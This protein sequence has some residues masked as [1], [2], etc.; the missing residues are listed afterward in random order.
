MRKIDTIIIH[1]SASDRKEADDI[2][3]IRK[4]H[5]DKGWDDVGYHYFIKSDGEVQVGREHKKIGA[6]ALKYNA[7]S[8]GICLHGLH[9]EDFTD[10][11]F[12]A[13]ASLCDDLI[14][15]YNIKSII[16]H[17]FVANKKC[18]VFNVPKEIYR[19]LGKC[20]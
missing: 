13:C 19:R 12:E 20:N 16:P 1:C 10:E 6:H 5:T 14:D 15:K 2:G 8:L 17:N 3:V 18:P 9:A 11:Q 4:W 7:E